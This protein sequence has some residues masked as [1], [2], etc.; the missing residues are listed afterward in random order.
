MK[1]FLPSAFIVFFV[2]FA[3][4]GKTQSNI[5][6]ASLFD[7]NDVLKI[8]LTGDIRALMN[9][10]VDNAQNHPLLLSYKA[11]NGNEVSLSIQ[12]KTR[13]HFR[14]TMGNC[15]YPPLLLQFT[16]NDTLVSSIFS[17]Q[18]KLKLVMPC[19]GDDYVVRE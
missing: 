7:A 2:L 10:R 14:R 19:I 1:I 5:D 18:N 13:G 16:K 8:R 17:V 11:E 15:T 9:D 12:A 3:S 4:T 6:S